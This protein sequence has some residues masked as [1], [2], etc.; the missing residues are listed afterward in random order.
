MV[1]KIIFSVLV[2]IIF[3]CSKEEVPKQV[4]LQYD[5]DSKILLINDEVNIDLNLDFERFFKEQKLKVNKRASKEYIYYNFVK[6]PSIVFSIEKQNVR[7]K[8]IIFYMKSKLPKYQG[9][10]I[11]SIST[12]D[13]KITPTLS[14]DIVK[15]YLNDNSFK[16]SINDFS[17]NGGAYITTDEYFINF[18]AFTFKPN[19][20]EQVEIY[21]N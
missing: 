5:T 12:P 3:S 20:L 13:L 19:Y 7:R 16:Y 14:M 4:N 8:R 6:Y 2:F 21:L 15:K 11:E 9:A 10:V 18:F 17:K 1:K